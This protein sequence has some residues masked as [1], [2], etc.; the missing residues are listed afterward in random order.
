M[1]VDTEFLNDLQWLLVEPQDG[2]VTWPSGLWTPA[3]VL[4]SINR[5]QSQFLRQTQITAA[6][7]QLAVVSGTPTLGYPDD[8]IL[9]QEIVLAAGGT[10]S[11]LARSGTWQL[12][13]LA[14]TWQTDGGR[15]VVYADSEDPDLL[16]ALLGPTPNV[17]GIAY[18]IYVAIGDPISNDGTTSFVVPDE[19]TVT[20]LFGVLADLLNKVG[21]GEDL[22]RAQ[23]CQQRYDEGVLIWNLV[24]AGV[25]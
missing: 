10:S 15:P 21:R 18:L 5:V 11:E 3:E 19:A 14:A 4:A 17:N 23:Y 22:A 12:D 6:W 2:G 8:Y 16:Q 1:V 7:A 24:L 25:I 13:R 9:T 20:L